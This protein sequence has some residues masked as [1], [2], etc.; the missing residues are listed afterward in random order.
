MKV[1]VAQYKL[2][3]RA[4]VPEAAKVVKEATGGQRERSPRSTGNFSWTV[5]KSPYVTVRP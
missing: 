4:P 1:S 5:M 2:L 3:T